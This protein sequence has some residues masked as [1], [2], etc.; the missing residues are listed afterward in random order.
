[1]FLNGKL[2]AEPCSNDTIPNKDR[3]PLDLLYQAN[4]F[5]KWWVGGVGGKEGVIQ[6]GR[7]GL[8]IFHLCFLLLTPQVHEIWKYIWRITQRTGFQASKLSVRNQEQ[9][10]ACSSQ[11]TRQ[12]S[13]ECTKRQQGILLFL[14][15]MINLFKQ[16]SHSIHQP[17]I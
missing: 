14:V 11:S 13:V 1:M 4:L 7:Q 3:G 10:H 5:R 8:F 16:C 12:A 6:T 17:G 2:T 15:A 9:Y